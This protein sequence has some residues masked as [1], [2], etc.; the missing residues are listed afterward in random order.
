MN[1]DLRK[2]A[3]AALDLMQSKGWEF[4]SRV[5]ELEAEPQY[6]GKLDPNESDPLTLWAEIARL[7]CAIQGPQGFASWQDAATDERIRR[8]KAEAE[9]YALKAQQPQ[10]VPPLTMD[11]IADVIRESR[12]NATARD[13]STSYRPR[14]R[15]RGAPQLWGGGRGV[16]EYEIIALL[17]D[18]DALLARSEK[19]EAECER[20]RSRLRSRSNMSSTI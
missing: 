9:L 15:A 19:A 17:R 10:P 14:R 12:M 8:V 6:S 2:A 1:N 13:G 11:Q 4:T 7:Q 20:L 18:R 3:Q 16:K 5:I